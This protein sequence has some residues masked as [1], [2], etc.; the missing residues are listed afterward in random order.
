MSAPSEGDFKFYNSD[1]ELS[2]FFGTE[3]L[4]I[5]G[6]IPYH[7][8]ISS[9]D[10]IDDGWKQFGF[11]SAE[12]AQ[13][14]KMLEKFGSP[15]LKIPGKFP[16]DDLD[17]KIAAGEIDFQYH[18]DFSYQ[19]GCKTFWEVQEALKKKIHADLGLPQSFLENPH[20]QINLLAPE[21][22]SAFYDHNPSLI[23]IYKPAPIIQTTLHELTQHYDE[24]CKY[25]NPADPAVLA[26]IKEVREK[27]Q[28]CGRGVRGDS[29]IKPY[30]VNMATGEVYG[31]RTLPEPFSFLQD[32]QFQP[33]HRYSNE[34]VWE[35]RLKNWR[36]FPDYDP[37][38]F[39]PFR[40]HQI[41]AEQLS[42]PKRYKPDTKNDLLL[43]GK[44]A[45]RELGLIQKMNSRRGGPECLSSYVPAYHFTLTESGDF[46]VR[47]SAPVIGHSVVAEYD[48]KPEEIEIVM[49]ALYDVFYEAVAER[50]SDF[51][52]R[53]EVKLIDHLTGEVLL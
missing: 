38:P 37:H 11:N 13:A 31:K 28:M 15:V 16:I 32:A 26:K 8:Q 3:T 22:P 36:Q 46:L 48:L 53:N 30:I 23:P 6:A 35:L 24:L 34:Q 40:S 45:H 52:L 18:Q 43:F 9:P 47:V 14:A 19:Y 50:L 4:S 20:Q 33:E 25:G 49:P 17:S 10:Q 5:G 44:D 51:D 41:L 2:E 7:P 29:R 39:K 12:I 1:P 42:R 27:I 21:S